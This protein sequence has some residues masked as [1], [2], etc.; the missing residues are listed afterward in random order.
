M[1]HLTARVDAREQDEAAARLPAAARE[2]FITMPVPDRRHAI[3]V[4]R[5]LEAE[6]HHDPELLA[7]ALLHDVAKGRRMRVWHRV[8][9]VLL[10][11]VAPGA[12]RRLASEDPRSRRHP[13]YLY[14]EH[15]RLSAE[16]ALRVGCAPRT[17]GF[18]RGQVRP[19]DRRLLEALRR[20]D[21]AA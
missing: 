12:L 9:G 6:G 20:A 18:I 5:R 1:A 21:A 16:A 13:L 2:L 15:P 19:P 8:A 17:A 4:A 14:L 3:D 10:E 11:A 7:A